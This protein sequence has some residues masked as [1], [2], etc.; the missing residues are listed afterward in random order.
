MSYE[1]DH[2]PD[3][4]RDRAVDSF[5]FGDSHL[6]DAGHGAD[7]SDGSLNHGVE[8]AT[9]AAAI[10]RESYDVDGEADSS[11]DGDPFAISGVKCGPASKRRRAPLPRPDLVLGH[12]AAAR[13]QPQHHHHHHDHQ[14]H[15]LLLPPKLEITGL[16]SPLSDASAFLCGTRM[17][18]PVDVDF[19]SSTASA[20]GAR[21]HLAPPPP[22]SSQHDSM[23]RQRLQQQQQL[24]QQQQFQQKKLQLQQAMNPPSPI[25][26]RK[27]RTPKNSA[28]GKKNDQRTSSKLSEAVKTSARGATKATKGRRRSGSGGAGAAPARSGSGGGSS[29]SSSGSRSRSKS[30]EKGRASGT[31]QQERRIK[32]N[33]AERT[34]TRTISQKIKRLHELLEHEGHPVKNEKLH[35]ITEALQYIKTLTAK[36]HAAKRTPREAGFGANHGTPRLVGAKKE[37]AAVGDREHAMA[38]TRVKIE[39]NNNSILSPSNVHNVA[40]AAVAQDL[41]PYVVLGL[42]LQILYCSPQFSAGLLHLTKRPHL[43]FGSIFTLMYGKSFAPPPPPPSTDSK[44]NAFGGGPSAGSHQLWRQL[45]DIA[46]ERIERAASVKADSGGESA[47]DGD[48]NSSSATGTTRASSSA[49]LTCEGSI[50]Q[51]IDCFVVPDTQTKHWF[52]LDI[53]VVPLLPAIPNHGAAAGSDPPAS[54]GTDNATSTATDA[55]SKARVGLM[56]A[57]LPLSHFPARDVKP[58]LRVLRHD[59]AVPV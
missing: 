29:G 52:R 50:A 2:P 12:H 59:V 19:G 23:E 24:L 9:R 8:T 16:P 10:G 27:T 1:F 45:V 44:S 54:G 32:H 7:F 33:A 36:V 51:V 40:R 37:N 13:H 28:G 57:L 49:S 30:R 34:R 47:A 18:S 56:A 43:N 46:K 22:S 6:F 31:E 4:S 21:P 20:V 25:L 42:D 39:G 26:K 38:T 53:S 48:S 58:Q 5:L 15:H 3:G 14:Y 11:F 17:P 41:A 55:T 35:I